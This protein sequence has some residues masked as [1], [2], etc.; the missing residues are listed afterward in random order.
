MAEICLNYKI[1]SAEVTFAELGAN[2]DKYL[3]YVRAYQTD[4]SYLYIEARLKIQKDL[5]GTADAVIFDNGH[6][7]IIDLKYGRSKVKAFKNKQLMTYALAAMKTYKK[8]HKVNKVTVHI[9]QPYINHF[10]SYSPTMKE[11]KQFKKEIKAGAKLA[12][13]DDAE[14][15]YSSK[16]CYWCTAKFNCQAFIDATCT[17]VEEETPKFMKGKK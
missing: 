11:L 13:S 9:A 1:V 17:P 16:G 10:E 15:V 2:V 14:C 4:T 8:K 7:H 6:L 5:W 12:L 3:Q